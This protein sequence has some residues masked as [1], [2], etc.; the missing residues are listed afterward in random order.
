MSETEL[1]DAARAYDGLQ[2][3]AQFLLREEFGRRSLEP[4]L[5]E[6]KLWQL[7]S[8]QNLVT[9]AT[10]RDLSEAIVARAALESADIPC[11]LQ[12]ENMIRMDW[13]YS[14]FL[15]GLRLQ[16]PVPDVARAHEVLSAP[17]PESI[18][19]DDEPGFDQPICPKCGSDDIDLQKPSR[20]ALPLLY[21]FGIPIPSRS[22]HPGKEV[23]HCL[24]CSCT[25]LDEG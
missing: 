5:I 4:P 22:K 21:F 6:E 23:W 17:R 15:G 24:T 20:A 7:P 2:P 8:F 18:D 3:E 10:Y 16:A 14:N 25:W 9:V 1:M 19:F 12:D 11:F 13:G